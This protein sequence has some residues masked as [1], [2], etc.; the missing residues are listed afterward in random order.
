MII[1]G[2]YLF[3]ENFITTL[4]LLLLTGRLT[5]YIPG[6]ARLLAG[7]LIGAVASF[8]IFMQLSVWSSIILRI[9]A[10]FGCI[11]VTYG[12]INLLIKS[13]LFFVLTFT[14]GGMV[15]ALLFWLREP[16]IN[17]QGIVYME[18]LTY[19]KLISLGIIAFGFTYWFV[20]L[21]RSKGEISNVTGK[22]VMKYDGQK[23]CFSAYVDSGNNLK[24]P[25][26]GRPV[27]LIDKKGARK[28]PL[29]L[30]TCITNCERIRL[31]PYKAVGVDY[32]IMPGVRVDEIEYGNHRV[33]DVYLAFYDGVFEKY[34]MLLNKV[35][36]EGG[37]LE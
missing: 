26:S 19:L 27:A 5:G 1:Y 13:L 11:F 30:S 6:I 22:A 28:L 2:E 12:H 36:L 8:M 33:K 35:F 17:H 4:L 23:Y 7:S 15:M 16:A 31:I 3:I 9:A 10:G 25:I 18:S 24:E 21:V 37:L 32:G 20:K 29:D 34:E 14:S